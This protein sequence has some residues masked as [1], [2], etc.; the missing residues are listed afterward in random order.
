MYSLNAFVRP[1]FVSD[2][3]YINSDLVLRAFASWAERDRKDRLFLVKKTVCLFVSSIPR[4]TSL[5]FSRSL[6]FG[7]EDRRFLLTLLAINRLK[8]HI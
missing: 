2:P 3:A 5:S 8:T 7:V 1:V 6:R 4:A